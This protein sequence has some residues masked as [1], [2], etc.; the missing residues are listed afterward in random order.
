MKRVNEIVWAVL[1]GIIITSFI[2][3]SVFGAGAAETSAEIRP[4]QVIK[5][6]TVGGSGGWD[7]LTA[8][9]QAHRCTYLMLHKLWYSI[10]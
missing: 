3:G 10:P 9:S 6:F 7:Y 8:D 2:A 5:T 4:L 1:T